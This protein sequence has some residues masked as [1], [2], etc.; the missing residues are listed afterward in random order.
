MA[1]SELRASAAVR[2]PP[3]DEDET[4]DVGDWRAPDDEVLRTF[5]TPNLSTKRDRLARWHPL[6]RDARIRFFEE[7]HYYEID[8][9]RAPRSVT[10][11]VHQFE[12]AFD[13]PR[14]AARMQ[15]SSRWTTRC[16][17]FRKADGEIMTPE[18]MAEHW[19]RN[20]R[21][22]AARGTLMHYQIEQWL[23]GYS[24]AEP[25]SFEFRCFLRFVDD[26]LAPRR[27]V[28]FRTELSI[29]HCGLRCAGQIDFLA[30]ELSTESY[31]LFDWKRCKKLETDSPYNERLKAP[32]DHL[33]KCNYVL[34][35]LQLNIYRYILESEYGL[36]ISAMYLAVFHPNGRGPVCAEVPRLEEEMDALLA[37]ERSAGRAGE[38]R[39]GPDAAFLEK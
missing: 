27:I 14:V 12:T 20:G 33:P 21:V 28:P 24:I 31:V 23:N 38:A 17:E 19:K 35:A 5:T 16:E 8:G 29:F 36:R 15:R 11:L 18:E 22:Q 39:P 13:G 4:P 30:Y 7:E 3:P 34:Y 26:F 9:A 32:L 2:L 37:F 25:H 10:A 1:H 6:A